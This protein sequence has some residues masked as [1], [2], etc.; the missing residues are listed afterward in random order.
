[1]LRLQ[2]GLAVLAQRDELGTL[3]R[4]R[5]WRKRLGILGAAAVLALAVIGLCL[6]W[7][8]RE[9]PAGVL[10]L[11]VAELQM[12]ARALTI[13][14]PYVFARTRCRGARNRAPQRAA[15]DRAQARTLGEQ[16]HGPI[17]VDSRAIGCGRWASAGGHAR[18][19]RVGSRRLRDRVPGFRRVD[20]GKVCRCAEAE[21]PRTGGSRGPV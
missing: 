18:L 5:P 14:G 10:A 15:R 4:E 12:G 3:L 6:W 9:P 7:A 19:G 1:V 11:S 2:E 20:V 16:H 8:S 21:R 13:E 17:S